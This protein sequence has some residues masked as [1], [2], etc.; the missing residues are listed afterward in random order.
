MS[1]S[2]RGSSLEFDVSLVRDNAA[3]KSL[4]EP[5][6]VSLTFPPNETMQRLK[7]SEESTH[8]LSAEQLRWKCD[9]NE[10]NFETTAD[11]DPESGVL[12]QDD[13]REALMFGIECDAP[14]QN[15]FVR[16]ARGTGRLTMVRQ[17]LADLE[18]TTEKKRDRCYV[19]NFKRPDH[20]RLISLAPG[21]ASEF[22]RRLGE[23]AKYIGEG[24]IKALEGEPYATQRNAIGERV[25]KD[26][27]QVTKPLEAELE[28]NSMALVQM[29]NGPMM[30]TVI[31]PVVDGSPVPPDQLNSLVKQG[32]LP[33]ERWKQFEEAYPKFEK[34]LRDISRKVNER[35][36]E[37][38]T[39]VREFNERAARNLIDE[40]VDPIRCDYPT[41]EVDTFLN[42]IVEDAVEFRITPQ[43]NPSDLTELYGVNVVLE[44][45][46]GNARPVI[47]EHTPTIVNLLGTV[48]PS[49]DGGGRAISDFRG[50]RGGALLSA[51]NGYLIL[52]ADDLVAE[53]GAWRSLMRTLRTGQLEIV[54]HEVGWMQPYVVVQPE[55]IDINVR[56]ILI[57]D[58]QTYFKLDYIDSDFGE[59][60]KVLA[61]FDNELPRD[62]RSVKQYAAVVSR[63][64][65]S[66]SLLPFHKTAI[67]RLSE[68][69][70]RIVSRDEKLTAR[71]GRIADIARESAFL[72]KRKGEAAVSAD[73][74]SEAISR[75]K[76][77]ASL[78]CRKFQEMVE[79]GSILVR[80]KGEVVGQI[81]GLAV[82][83]SG[84]LTYGFPA[85][86]TST[87]G[88]GRAGL[89]NIEGTAQM[90]GSIHT[91]GFHILG[92][93]LRYLLKTKHPL[94]FSASIAFEQSYGGI[95]GDSASGAEMVC[96]LSALTGIPIRQT[97]A[98]TGAIDQHGHVEAIGGVNEKIEGFFDICSHFGLTGDQGVV[99]PKSNAG[100]L[101]LRQEVV[102]ACANGEFHVYAVERIEDAVELMTGVPAGE[103]VDGTY[104]EGT[105]LGEAVRLANEYWRLTLASP[106]KMT[107]TVPGELAADEEES[108]ETPT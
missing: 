61:D 59:L 36:R 26:V 60:F 65:K 21:T 49:M 48:E 77:R 85:R 1:R 71:F 32:N 12:G 107:T 31:F 108:S 63:V 8:K 20:P 34:Q 5:Y 56:V 44:H 51:D 58:A 79:R 73:S 81:N 92:G 29:K 100:D 67:G 55:A 101:M 80:T 75:T 7:M 39:L 70:A 88:P 91:K 10:L 41:S 6:N 17:L 89:I 47:E 84:P 103:F 38:G 15:V 30:Q 27:E 52:D 62:E 19:H 18:L 78:P 2:N 4:L 46:D 106:A 86:I 43:E 37:G 54:P 22:R 87:I 11:L 14:G 24:L 74:V 98:M 94:A 28:K 69:G 82:M 25:Q 102:D 42:E 23:L 68:H 104:S 45:R 50:I 83:R 105:V 40:Y 95:D 33:E 97:M 93:L 35:M 16:G 64:S 57:G 90:S 9:L 53:P 99:I 76:K 13:A 72:A 3:T 96:L 66:E